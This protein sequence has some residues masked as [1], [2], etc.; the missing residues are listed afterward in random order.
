VIDLPGVGENYQDHAITTSLFKIPNT[1]ETWDVFANPIPNA[2][3][4]SLYET[5]RTGPYASSIN[6]VAFASATKFTG[7]RTLLSQW[8]R[9]I[10]A[11][12]NA[13]NPSPGRRAVYAI[14]RQRLMWNDPSATVE[15][16]C[17]PVLSF[18]QFF[19]PN[20]SF[21]HIA[22]IQSHPFS[23]GSIHL[24]SSNPLVP[25]LID[26]NAWAFDIDKDIAIQ[27]AKY[28][29]KIA[30]TAPFSAEIESLVYPGTN[31]TTDEEWGDFIASTI[32]Q[33]YHPTGTNAM[34][35]KAYGGVVDPTLKVYG[36]NNIRVV[37]VSIL[38]FNLATH[39]AGTTYAIAEQAADIIKVVYG[40]PISP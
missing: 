3:A 17:A 24:N 27:G 28:A 29:R 21:V 31:V 30:E 10:D 12:F 22:S 11:Q 20:A 37:D 26:L 38:P 13:S 9:S 34:L 32:N 14:E 33:P 23:R 6:V 2:T 16:Y 36:T 18:P 8:L 19:E 1:I 5:N 15:F 4:F 39:L 25:P 35:P 7:N 40:F